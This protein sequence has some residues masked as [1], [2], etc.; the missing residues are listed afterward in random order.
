MLT[1]G[2]AVGDVDRDGRAVAGL[3]RAELVLPDAGLPTVL[4]LVEALP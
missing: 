3:T 4:T 1:R 2:A